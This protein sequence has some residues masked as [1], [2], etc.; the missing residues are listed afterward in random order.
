M[1]ALLGIEGAHA[2][3]GSLDNVTTFARRGVRYIGVLHFSANEAGYPAYGRGR[4]DT[5]GLTSWG[6]ELVERCEK[7]IEHV[8]SARREPIY[9]RRARPGRLDRP[10]PAPLRHP[11]QHGIQRP[12]AQPV[13]VVMELFQHPVAVHA[14]RFACVV[15][16]V[17]LPERQQEFPRDRIAHR[18]AIILRYS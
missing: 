16:D 6:S 11:R 8:A 18:P 7:A 2:L 3:E 1:G 10:Q 9:P 14:V 17:D 5:D 4:H 15:Q 12:R 13:S